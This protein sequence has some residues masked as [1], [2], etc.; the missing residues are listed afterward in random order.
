MKQSTIVTMPGKTILD[1]AIGVLSENGNRLMGP[2]MIAETGISYGVIRVPRGRTR[3]YVYQILQ[4]VMHDNFRY[5][6]SPS[7]S[8]PFKGRYR[9]R[10]AA[11]RS[12]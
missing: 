4:S 3:G 5:A 7:I 9:V 2:K 8:R 6:K 11:L 12:K 1:T 10:K